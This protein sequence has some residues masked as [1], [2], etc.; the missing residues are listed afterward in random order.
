[1]SWVFTFQ[2]VCTGAQKAEIA[3]SWLPGSR[4]QLYCWPKASLLTPV[5]ICFLISEMRGAIA[6]AFLMALRS[7]RESQPCN[8]G[9]AGD[10]CSGDSDWVYMARL[11]SPSTLGNPLITLNYWFLFIM[12]A[13]GMTCIR[14]PFLLIDR[15]IQMKFF[16]W[17]PANREGSGLCALL[18]T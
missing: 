17:L 5:S 14:F 16:F 2:V 3:V 11:P 15:K 7:F 12:L 4:S 1:M 6:G 13:P 18:L 9:V 8:R 10:E